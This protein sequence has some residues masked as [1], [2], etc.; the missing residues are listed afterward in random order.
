METTDELEE[1]DWQSTSEAVRDAHRSVSVPPQHRCIPSSVSVDGMSLHSNFRLA[2]EVGTA[3]DLAQPGGFRRAHVLADETAS[4]KQIT[5][6]QAP[7]EVRLEVIGAPPSFFITD[8]LQ[9]RPDGTVY[10]FESRQ[11]RRGGKPSIIASPYGEVPTKQKRFKLWIWR[12]DLIP[13]WCTFSYL[14]G[15]FLFTAGSFS[16]MIPGVGDMGHGAPEWEA[17]LTV[18]I[19]FAVGAF[20]FTTG[21]YLAFVATINANLQEE[22][23]HLDPKGS[24]HRAGRAMARRGGGGCLP[25]R[26]AHIDLLDMTV[27]S[28]C[29]LKCCVPDAYCWWAYQ[30]HSLLYWSSLILV[31]GTLFFGVA[32]ACG[33]PHALDW[34]KTSHE[35]HWTAEVR[36]RAART[37]LTPRLQLRLR[38]PR[39]ARSRL[40]VLIPDCFVPFDS[41]PSLL[42]F[43][44]MAQDFWRFIGEASGKHFEVLGELSGGSVSGR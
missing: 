24:V 30:P 31:I 15:G 36:R 42:Q 35:A 27:T 23:Q 2:P 25:C 8:V 43:L 28:A 21:A 41:S 20:W 3:S 32:C 38:S 39:Y 18:F 12:P 40:P 5:Y 37:A 17:N 4:E 14:I 33:F 1:P 7:L 9:T 16:W 6:A 10:R 13:W 44:A 22:L 19:P 29:R 34:A 11:Y 26:G